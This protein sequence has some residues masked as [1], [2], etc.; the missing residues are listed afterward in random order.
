[1]VRAKVLIVEDEAIVAMGIKHKLEKLGHRVIAMVTSG[2][3]AIHATKEYDVDIILMDIV[4]KGDMDGIDTANVIHSTEDIPIIYLT[5]YADDEMLERAKITQPYGYIIKPFK[6]AELNANIEMALFKHN[7]IKK[8]MDNVPH[9]I[10]DD[11]S[12]F[13]A[14]TVPNNDEELNF[15]LL[16]IFGDSL[17]SS[18]KSGFYE[19][20]N[21]NG[22]T[23]DSDGGEILECYMDWLNEVF[24]DLGVTNNFKLEEYSMDLEFTNCPW[25]NQAEKNPIYCLNCHSIIKK[26]LDWAELEG[27]IT[28]K[29]SIAFGDDI[30]DFYFEF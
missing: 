24:S 9:N 17:E 5:A 2:K 6:S 8:D 26:G 18:Y 25:K 27:K 14:Q 28:R 13:I 4:I 23:D 21:S 29:L 30:C 3:E 16:D 19:Y 15:K 7:Q 10:I 12:E 20:L 22:I 1:L 11:F